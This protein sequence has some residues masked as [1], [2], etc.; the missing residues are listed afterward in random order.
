[1]FEAGGRTLDRCRS[2]AVGAA[3]LALLLG[4]TPRPL[5]PS[6]PSCPLGRSEV[7][8]IP[9]L[10]SWV[11]KPKYSRTRSKHSGPFGRRHPALTL[12][13][14]ARHPSGWPAAEPMAQVDWAATLTT[15]LVPNRSTHMPNVSP[16][17]AF[18]NGTVT[19]PPSL[20]R[21]Q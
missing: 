9:L 8:R 2:S 5:F 12:S 3:H 10:G 7:R 4:L 15:Q 18:S 17:G 16:Q 14:P 21:S 11:N 20:R 19:L 13:L 1:M 6:V